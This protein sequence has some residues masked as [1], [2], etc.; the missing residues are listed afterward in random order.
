MGR[1]AAR[2]AEEVVRLPGKRDLLSAEDWKF[3]TDNALAVDGDWLEW[4]TQQK[5][6]KGGEGERGDEPA[7]VLLRDLGLA[8]ATS[9]D[10]IVAAASRKVFQLQSVPLEQCVQ[11]AQILAALGATVPAGFQYATREL[12][13]RDSSLHVVYDPHGVVEDLTSA[14]WGEEHLLHDDY[15]NEFKS[16]TAQ[17]WA[18][19]VAS[20][21]S[22]LHLALPVIKKEQHFWGRHSFE[23]HLR[24][25]GVGGSVGYPYSSGRIDVEDWFFDD[26]VIRHW[27]SVA[28]VKPDLHVLALESILKGPPSG[29]E[30]KL[31]AE[32]QQNGRVYKRRV[33]CGPI[34]SAWIAL[35]RS[36]RCLRDTHG[37]ARL[38]AELLLRTPDTEVLRDIEP[39]VA[40]ELDTSANRR[41]LELL[42]VRSTP[43]GTKK[44]IERL[45][46][47]TLLPNPAAL[48]IEISKLYEALDRIVGR[49]APAEL[50][51][52]AESFE[53]ESL[54]LSESGEWVT[55]GEICIR[56]DEDGDAGC[57][58]HLF[59]NLSMWPRLGVAERPAFE[60]SLEWLSSLP[61]GGRVEGAAVARVRSILRR[62]PK[63]AW[64]T[65][66][67]WLSLGLTWEPVARLVNRQTSPSIG[68]WEG[69]APG[70]K[71][72]TADLRMVPEIVWQ[73]PPFA[74]LRELVEAVEYE[75]T[76]VRE[77]GSV[78]PKAWLRELGK[79][80]CRLKF[81]D[82]QHTL[83]VRGVAERMRQTQW[84][85]IS[86]LEVTPYV[87]GVPAGTPM[88]PRVLWQELKLYVHG[89]TSVARL[90]KD[91]A[92]ELGRPFNDR[93]VTEAITA[94]IE[95]DAGYVSEFLADQF[96][97]EMEPE[98][99]LG[100]GATNEAGDSGDS[101]GTE[102]PEAAESEA[103]AEAEAAEDEADDAGEIA[104]RKQGGGGQQARP[105]STPK[106]DLVDRYAAK[107]GFKWHPGEK[108]YAH[109]DGRWIERA[110]APFHWVEKT[111]E[112]QATLRLWV[113]DQ[114][115]AQGI[116]VPAEVWSLLRSDPKCSALL[117]TDAVEAPV[118]F[119][120]ETLAEM[121]GEKRVRL[122]P[123]RYRI[124]EIHE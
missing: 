28:D 82:E 25:L 2:A 30:D 15:T 17:A 51:A 83:H 62:E 101:E 80:L 102:S 106:P 100:D 122:Y 35:F 116:E 72:A 73:Q 99:P 67:H 107:R 124:V 81:E 69:L 1:T 96:E 59:R 93:S 111:A 85:P 58:H 84:Q 95:R 50:R 4:L 117:L 118:V 92:E 26:E 14:K 3:V 46:A 22:G 36:K 109:S 87:D 16:C 88:T 9:V 41:L 64:E 61:S 76:D 119:N 39:F 42:G 77:S 20:G 8:D 54:V 114:T 113:Q 105:G 38:P 13:R 48:L 65:C 5:S 68:K 7:L 47:L 21:K 34:P 10:K 6:K 75:Q 103:G 60:R 110:E 29:W 86:R 104:S 70:V 43:S 44:I 79:V 52:A 19:W 91:L 66:G 23:E 11:F 53:Q 90:H 24:Q 37:N 63:R 89:G 71:Q 112:G 97:L 55:S 33:S 56:P 12:K 121:Q 40:A 18:D 27:R 94:C 32:A 49:C 74:A 45:K 120:G 123:A 108:Y 57:I 115:L 98:L 78:V 31:D